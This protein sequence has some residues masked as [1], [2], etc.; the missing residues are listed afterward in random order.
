MVLD[1]DITT[2]LLPKKIK[3]SAIPREIVETITE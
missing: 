1:C 3:A 2:I